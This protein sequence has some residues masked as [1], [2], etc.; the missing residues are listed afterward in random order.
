MNTGLHFG[1]RIV[2]RTCAWSRSG[3]TVGI[4]SP[5]WLFGTI[6]E[7]T[8]ARIRRGL[9]ELKPAEIRVLGQ[10]TQGLSALEMGEALDLTERTVNTHVHRILAACGCQKFLLIRVCCYE[11]SKDAELFSSLE[12]KLQLYPA[13][14]WTRRPKAAGPRKVRAR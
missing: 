4:M 10:L 2:G 5:H 3:A 12:A 8:V 1:G 6:P 13:N 7:T 9:L 11:L 14:S